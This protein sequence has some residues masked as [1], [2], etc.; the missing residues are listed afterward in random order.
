MT[1]VEA[2][3]YPLLAGMEWVL[4]AMTSATGSPGMAAITLSA[5]TF[6]VTWPVMRWADTFARAES[7][8]EELNER[9]RR[10]ELVLPGNVD[11]PELESTRRDVA[12]LRLPVER[13]QMQFINNRETAHYRS[14]FEDSADPEQRRRL[15]RIWMRAGGGP[16]YDG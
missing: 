9:P 11:V 13:G 10:L 1:I 14:E 16:G 8:L 7:E 4:D 3:L 2:T 6:V 15:I 5:L 12:R